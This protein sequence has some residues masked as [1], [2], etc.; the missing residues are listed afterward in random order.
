MSFNICM[1]CSLPFRPVPQVPN[2]AYCSQPAC[3]RK[4]RQRWNQQKL[5]DDPDYQDNKQRS[6]RDWM[7]RNPD[8]WRQYRADHPD[9]TDRNRS[10]QRVKTPTPKPTTL[11]KRDESNG[12]HPFK[13]GVYRIAPLQRMDGDISG[14]WTVELSPICLNSDC[15]KD[16]CKVDACKDRT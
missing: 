16:A 13:A 1:C 4:R 14:T 11:A 6:Q 7:D 10:R 5:K 3:Q 15:T 2:Q 12:P 8:Y 9:Y